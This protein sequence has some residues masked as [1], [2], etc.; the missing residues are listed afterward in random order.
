MDVVE[1]GPQLA[2][3]LWASEFSVPSSWKV[4]EKG[5]DSDSWK[6]VDGN[7][8]GAGESGDCEAKES[9]PHV[10]QHCDDKPF[11]RWANRKRE[12]VD[13]RPRV[14]HALRENVAA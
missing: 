10:A 14:A 13:W 9:H 6:I 4:P 2:S 5:V 1:F 12:V 11:G 8:A 7:A 3:F